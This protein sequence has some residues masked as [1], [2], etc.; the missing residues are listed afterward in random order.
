MV[1][2]K[3]NY[4]RNAAPISALV[5]EPTVRGRR[6]GTGRERSRY[7]GHGRLE[8]IIDEV[9]IENVLVNDNPPGQHEEME[10]NKEFEDVEDIGEEGGVPT[11]NASV[12]LFDELLDQQ[13]I[14]FLKGLAGPAK[15]TSSQAPVNTL[16]ACTLPKSGE[17]RCNDDCFHPLLG[18]VMTGNEHYMMTMFLNL[19]PLVFL[20]SG[21]EYAYCFNLD[22][23]KRLYWV[24]LSSMRLSAFPFNLN[25]RPST[26]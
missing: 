23:Y 2:T 5:E 13:I 17:T 21:T 7:R 15:L 6:R 3:F 10:E 19:K 26:V 18:L 22:C 1:N 24:L 9:Q 11:G 20:G 4:V 14:S 8:V 25:V 12:P 16:V